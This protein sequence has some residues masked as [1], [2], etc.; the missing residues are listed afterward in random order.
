LEE[1]FWCGVTEIEFSQQ[2][3]RLQETFGKSAYGTERVKLIW[4]EVKDLAPDWFASVVGGFIGTLRQ[5]PLLPD[6]SERASQE[7]E[8]L[9]RIEKDNKLVHDWTANP[10]CNLCR[11]NGIYLC[12]QNGNSGPY[13]FRCVCSA[14]ISDPR[15]QIPQ[16]K[17]CHA[18]EGFT[19]YQVD[20]AKEVV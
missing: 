8:R 18:D 11:D 7:R 19:Y 13:A 17:K 2:L 10:N 15:K 12:L 14:G 9:W 16:Y 3:N 5:A 4:K 6:I 20:W 1:S